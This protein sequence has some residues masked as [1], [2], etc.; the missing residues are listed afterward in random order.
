MGNTWDRRTYKQLKP[1][2]RN[3]IG[4]DCTVAQGIEIELDYEFFAYHLKTDIQR[5]V[6]MFIQRNHL[7][8]IGGSDADESVK[9]SLDDI[10]LALSLKTHTRT[11]QIKNT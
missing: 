3:V 1:R 5:V 11:L 7:F 4:V 6:D 8:A 9:L 10:Q 2:T